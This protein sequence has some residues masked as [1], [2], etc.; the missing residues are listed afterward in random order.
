MRDFTLINNKT[1]IGEKVETKQ[2]RQTNPIAKKFLKF[3]KENLNKFS[4]KEL[5]NVSD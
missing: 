5:F 4:V 3:R 1:K 2:I